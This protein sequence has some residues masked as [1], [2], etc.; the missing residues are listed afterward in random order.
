MK[1]GPCVVWQ[2]DIP[3][4]FRYLS[5]M[6]IPIAPRIL[7]AERLRGGI[8]VTFEDGRSALYP[9]ALLHAVFAQAE[10]LDEGELTER[11]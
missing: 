9:A 6:E 1:I 2:A 7:Y 4:G 10:R 5:Q 8:I 11:D 3:V